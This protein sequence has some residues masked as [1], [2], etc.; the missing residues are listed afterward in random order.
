MIRKFFCFIWS[1]QTIPTE[2][3]SQQTPERGLLNC[4]RDLCLMSQVIRALSLSLYRSSALLLSTKWAHCF[5]NQDPSF[6]GPRELLGLLLPPKEDKTEEISIIVIV[7]FSSQKE[8]SHFLIS[9]LSGPGGEVADQRSCMGQGGSPP[10]RCQCPGQCGRWP[11]WTWQAPEVYIW[12]TR[13]SGPAA[14]RRC[15]PSP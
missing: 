5:S 11:R 12:E 15:C 6:W 14:Q 9:Q 2:N 1:G 4:T 8:D 3:L 7:H 13:A 10:W